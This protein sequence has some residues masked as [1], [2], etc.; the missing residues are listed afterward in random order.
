MCAENALA[1]RY[2]TL[3]IITIAGVPSGALK[4]KQAVAAYWS[5]ALALIPDLK[6]ELIDVL[7][8]VGSLTLYYKGTNARYAAEVFY[9]NAE[10]LVIKAFAHYAIDPQVDT[11]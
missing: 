8:G 5:K 10:G 2:H 11:H 4:G 1:M 9:F 7:S 6:F 3:F